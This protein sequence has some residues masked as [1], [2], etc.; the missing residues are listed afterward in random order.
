MTVH[1]KIVII[2]DLYFYHLHM[3]VL[4]IEVR[5]QKIGYRHCTLTLYWKTKKLSFSLKK[6]TK[7]IR[8]LEALML[9]NDPR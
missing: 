2:K 5:E 7:R 8:F 4:Q 6:R 9:E 1:L 3:G